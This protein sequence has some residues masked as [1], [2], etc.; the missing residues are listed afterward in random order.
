MNWEVEID[1]CALACVE[2]L[3]SRILLYSKIAQP[4]AL[5]VTYMDGMEWGVGGRTKK[6]R[7]SV[8]M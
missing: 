1:V 8:Y 4:N 7:K 2:Q 5:W 3:A 6:E